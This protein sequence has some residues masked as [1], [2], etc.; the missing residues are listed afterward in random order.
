M[1]C[2]DLRV[3]NMALYRLSRKWLRRT[4]SKSCTA[5]Y[6]QRDDTERASGASGAGL[7]GSGQL[8]RFFGVEPPGIVV[9]WIVKA[10][11]DFAGERGN[12]A[13]G[14]H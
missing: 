7:L 5:G 8:F 13:C 11:G 4:Q 10:V 3:F 1:H 12:L 6:L 9:G 2:T 14:A